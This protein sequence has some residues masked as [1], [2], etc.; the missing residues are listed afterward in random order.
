MLSLLCGRACKILHKSK[1]QDEHEDLHFQGTKIFTAIA[2]LGAIK[3]EQVW[4][5]PIGTPRMSRFGSVDVFIIN[6]GNTVFRLKSSHFEW[7]KCT[8]ACLTTSCGAIVQ[9][10]TM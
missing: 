7:L 3:A 5:S 6:D 2:C 10:P 9:V 1:G 4:K 8:R